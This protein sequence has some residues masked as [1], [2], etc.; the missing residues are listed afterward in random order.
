M[1]NE[2][3]LIAAV[4]GHVKQA[5]TTALDISFNEILDMWHSHELDITPDYQRLFRW[6]PAQQSRFIESLLLEMPVPPIFVIEEQE[7]TYQ[8]IDGLQRISSYLHLRGELNAPQADP[9]VKKGEK[10]KLVDCDIVE[11]LNGLTFDTLPS[12]LQ[13]RLKRRFIRM[14]VVRKETDRRFKYHMFKRLNTGGE[15]LSAQQVRNAAMRMLGD[16]F[17][18]FI[19]RMAAAADY[20]E[21]TKGLTFERRMTAFD[22]ELVL[23]FF[24]LKNS[25]SLF[26]HEVT[27]FL[28]EYME[29]IVDPARPGKFSYIE[30][31]ETFVKTFTLLSRALGEYVFGFTN[32]AKNDLNLGF[33]VYHFEAITV[34]IQAVLPKL[35]PGNAAQVDLLKETL[36]S[37]KLDP[38][39]ISITTGGGKN[40]PGPLAARINFVSERLKHAFP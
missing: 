4:A 39:F 26:K 30:E 21:C 13:I 22:E 34:G 18:N 9:P 14:E 37:V 2:A 11:E 40:S 23:R 7:N 36:K 1:T 31:E 24:A 6:T 32:R 3:T 10:L 15:I 28:D 19:I 20:K 16:E 8:L 27:D 17:P 25:Q 33:N 38:H 5:N 29:N 35:D 12:S